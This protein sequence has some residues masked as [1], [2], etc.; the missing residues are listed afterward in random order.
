MLQLVVGCICAIPGAMYAY[1]VPPDM[2]WLAAIVGAVFGFIGGVLATGAVLAFMPAANTH[3]S[4][5]AETYFR[6][7]RQ[8]AFAIKAYLVAVG[9]CLLVLTAAFT[10]A[11]PFLQ[12]HWWAI[13]IVVHTIP[14]LFAKFTQ[15]RIVDLGCP[16]C[17]HAFGLHNPFRPDQHR[18]DHC[19]EPFCDNVR[20]EQMSP[21]NQ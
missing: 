11:F 8:S 18:C 1:T 9:V 17:D 2:N 14:Y 6:Y 3:R 20:G 12:R 13:I 21:V 19:G 16:N 7:V 5:V 4:V 15:F 10:I